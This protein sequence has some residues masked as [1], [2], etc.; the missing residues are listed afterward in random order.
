[1]VRCMR[2]SNC[3]APQL[4]SCATHDRCHGSPSTHGQIHDPAE[5]LRCRSQQH[6]VSGS[7]SAILEQ[8]GLEA[9]GYTG[10][11]AGD[12]CEAASIL[13]KSGIS[14]EVKL[15]TPAV[16]I[17]VHT[18]NEIKKSVGVSLNVYIYPVAP[19]I[20]TAYVS[21]KQKLRGRVSCSLL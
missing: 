6:R 5:L 20:L 10:R 7:H 19:G 14:V 18:P 11:D 12:G 21:A 17:R 1:M 2:C 8:F 4:C 15:G 16:L 9:L 13:A 3:I